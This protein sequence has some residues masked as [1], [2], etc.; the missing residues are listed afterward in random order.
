MLA[1]NTLRMAST[2]IKYDL[3]PGNLSN[4][5]SWTKH[6]ITMNWC[7]G[8]NG[9]SVYSALTLGYRSLQIELTAFV[10]YTTCT[11]IYMI[12]HGS[13]VSA[14][15]RVSSSFCRLVI[16]ASSSGGASYSIPYSML[17]LKKHG[18]RVST[19]GDSYYSLA[20]VQSRLVIKAK[21]GEAKTGTA[22]IVMLLYLLTE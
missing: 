5:R 2:A 22:K 16:G 7:N 6:K 8:S 9:V 14:P 15:H 1:A 13:A 10:S 11:V 3:I 4:L 12:R 19:R 18:E 21:T 20:L 17:N